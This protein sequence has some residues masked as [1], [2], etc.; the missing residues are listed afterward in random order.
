MPT[1]TSNG[2]RL[3]IPPAED[4]NFSFRNEEG[5]DVKVCQKALCGVHGLV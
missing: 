3:G 5:I 1:L 4:S 2:K